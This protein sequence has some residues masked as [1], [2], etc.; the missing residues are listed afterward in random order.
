MQELSAVALGVLLLNLPFGFL[1]AGAQ[2][3]SPLWFVAVHAPVPFVVGLRHMA[4]LGWHVGT[5]PVLISAF[6]AGQFLGAR[7][8]RW[9]SSRS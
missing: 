1:R 9:W 6:V 4:G 7:L 3:F 2:R 5:F 8:R